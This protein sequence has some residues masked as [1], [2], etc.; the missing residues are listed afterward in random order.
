[1][2]TEYE[3]R[4][5]GAYKGISFVG[6]LHIDVLKNILS[7]RLIELY[8]LYGFLFILVSGLRCKSHVLK[9]D[10]AVFVIFIVGRLLLKIAAIKNRSTMFERRQE[11]V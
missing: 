2:K 11:H 4:E 8:I 1:L 7:A 6:I 3:Y 9:T 5:Q 10:F